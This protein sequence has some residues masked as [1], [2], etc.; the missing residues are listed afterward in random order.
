MRIR[1]AKQRMARLATTDLH[2]PF[3]QAR[4]FE[5]L[6]R[7][8]WGFSVTGEKFGGVSFLVRVARSA[9]KNARGFVFEFLCFKDALAHRFLAEAG[10][11]RVG[12]LAFDESSKSLRHCGSA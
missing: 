11:E 9:E 6:N 7:N 8:A 10:V 4:V 2:F 5:S 3:D 12:I 1:Q